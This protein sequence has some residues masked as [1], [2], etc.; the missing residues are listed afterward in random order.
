VVLFGPNSA[1][2]TSVL[3]AA[4]ELL[5][6]A[7]SPRIDPRGAEDVFAT[8]SIRFTLPG[9]GI[10]GSPDAEMYRDLLNG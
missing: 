7:S 1:G 6:A 10:S 5:R 2:K 4:V 9:A 3:E 8:G